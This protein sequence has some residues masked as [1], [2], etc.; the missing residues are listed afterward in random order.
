MKQQEQFTQILALKEQVQ[1][2]NTKISEKNQNLVNLQH[3]Y[4]NYEIKFEN[5]KKKIADLEHLLNKQ[6]SEMQKFNSKY[7]NRNIPYYSVVQE[8]FRE[9]L[10]KLATE[11]PHECQCNICLKSIQSIQKERDQD[12]VMEVE[13]SQKAKIEND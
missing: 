2:L 1:Q 9:Q 11:Y 6:K 8:F 4:K 7:L 12:A 5:S 10:P 13:N 3:E